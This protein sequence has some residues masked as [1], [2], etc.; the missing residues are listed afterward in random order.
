MT[1][2]ASSLAPI[3]LFFLSYLQKVITCLMPFEEK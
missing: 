1:D 2:F 3:F